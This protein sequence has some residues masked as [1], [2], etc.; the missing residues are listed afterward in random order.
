[1]QRYLKSAARV[2]E[3]YCRVEKKSTVRNTTKWGK[4]TPTSMV[5]TDIDCE[6]SRTLKP[7]RLVFVQDRTS[8]LSLSEEQ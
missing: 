3:V 6:I 5:L 2:G 8:Q 4:R 7:E 1:V